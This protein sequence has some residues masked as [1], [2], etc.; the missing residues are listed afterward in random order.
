MVFYGCLSEAA[1]RVGF[2]E[3]FLVALNE[4]RAQNRFASKAM[5]ISRMTR[6]SFPPSPGLLLESWPPTHLRQLPGEL[7]GSGAVFAPGSGNL[8]GYESGDIVR[9]DPAFRRDRPRDRRARPR[10]ASTVL[11]NDWTREHPSTR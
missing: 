2:Q 3:L 8:P 4:I 1:L 10:L 9:A 5:A 11:K 6:P 7:H